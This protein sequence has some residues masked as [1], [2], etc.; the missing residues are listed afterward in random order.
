[1][2]CCDGRYINNL[3]VILNDA[4]GET[5]NP[6]AEARAEQRQERHHLGKQWVLTRLVG[7]A[8]LVGEAEGDAEAAESPECVGAQE[9][10]LRWHPA[11]EAGHPVSTSTLIIS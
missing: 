9:G 8:V 11:R 1:M 3:T 4:E 7:P 10:G 6:I 5:R 2:N